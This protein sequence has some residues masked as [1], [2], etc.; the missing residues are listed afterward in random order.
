MN[1]EEIVLATSNEK[2]YEMIKEVFGDEL[3]LKQQ[4]VDIYE[5]QSLD[6][7]TVVREKA[8]SAYDKISEPVIVDDF[9]FYFEGLGRFPGPLIKHVLKETQLEGLEA[10]HNASEKECRM[11]CSVAYYDGS[12]V[13]VAEGQLEGRLDFEKADPTAKLTLMTAFVPEGYSQRL[14]DL[15]IQNHRHKAYQ[16]LS[17]MLEP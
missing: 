12:E 2:K 4:G 5:V 11:V 15:N 10:L 8:K 9:S 7:D 16:N 6:R 14:G 3:N 13:V 1:K 17:E